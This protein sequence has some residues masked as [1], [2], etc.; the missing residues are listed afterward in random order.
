M[1]T[2]KRKLTFLE[3]DNQQKSQMIKDL[4][5]SLHINKSIIETLL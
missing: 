1:Q 4:E 5:T 3:Q 2:L